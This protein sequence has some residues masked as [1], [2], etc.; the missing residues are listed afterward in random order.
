MAINIDDVYIQTYESNVRYL[1]QQQGSKLRSTCMVKNTNGE[2]HNWDRLAETAASLKASARTATPTD[3]SDW[4]RRVSIAAT[5][6][7]A[8]STE[9][10]DP[11]QM[12]IDP[13]SAIAHNQAMA[14][15][16]QFDDVIITAA[17]AAATIGDGST[18]AFPAGQEV[19]D[20]STQISFDMVTEVQEKF[21]ENDIDPSQPKVFVVGPKQVRKLMQ[22]TEQTSSDYV[23][24]QALQQ[25][26]ASGIVPNW[27]GFTWILSTRL[28]A[29]LAN[30]LDCLAFT[31]KAI[32]VQVNR[33]IST[34]M[35][36]DP[37]LSFAWRIYSAMTLGAVRV[38]DEQIVRAKVDDTAF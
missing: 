28:N 15:G 6:H 24:A 26:N 16:R 35:A 2:Q 4:S 34:E 10:E 37:S 13:N 36:K 32:G 20:Y 5:Y 11:V 12:L 22:L 30:Q 38:E 25:L 14:M 17:T 27:M 3:D 18:V 1:A 8:D 33:D 7:V 23:N 19:G 9:L 29:P 31:P 21:M